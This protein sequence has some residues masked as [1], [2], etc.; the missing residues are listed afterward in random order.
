MGFHS[1]FIL[2]HITSFETAMNFS[3]R[4]TIKL[5]LGIIKIISG[6]DFRPNL[7]FSFCVEIGSRIYYKLFWEPNF[8]FYYFDQFNIDLICNDC[9]LYC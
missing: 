7:F 8:S 5:Q 4:C 2:R 3:L 1:F 6:R 9:F